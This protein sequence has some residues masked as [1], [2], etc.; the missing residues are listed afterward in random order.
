MLLIVFIDTDRDSV[1]SLCIQSCVVETRNSEDAAATAC[2]AGR[3]VGAGTQAIEI[4][5][6]PE[7]FGGEPSL[8][9]PEPNLVIF[10]S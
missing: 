3:R 9:L 1:L 2:S 5:N 8:H 4:D 7:S 6:L 10:A